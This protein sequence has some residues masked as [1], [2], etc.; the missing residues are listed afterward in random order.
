MLTRLSQFYSILT[1]HRHGFSARSPGYRKG[2]IRRAGRTPAEVVFEA[3]TGKPA[4]AQ[5]TA[6]YG[7]F[8]SDKRRALVSAAADAPA[9][10]YLYQRAFG[11]TWKAS[12]RAAAMQIEAEWR[13]VLSVRGQMFKA[14]GMK[15]TLTGDDRLPGSLLVTK[16]EEVPA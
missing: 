11:S 15:D 10:L 3:L 6:L 12:G 14:L 13:A 9:L 5:S 1:E 2:T 16:K 4:S 7:L 8:Q